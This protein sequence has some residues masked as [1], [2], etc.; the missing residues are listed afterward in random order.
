[1]NEIGNDSLNENEKLV[2]EMLKYDFD[3]K[4]ISQ[5]LGISEHTVNSHKS[6]LERMGLI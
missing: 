3:E 2:L 6:K 5:K 1:M 4:E